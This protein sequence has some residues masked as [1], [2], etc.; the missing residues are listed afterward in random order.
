VV[1]GWQ[2]RNAH[3][4]SRVQ[5]VHSETAYMTDVALAWIAAQGESPWVLLLSY[6]KPHW[7]YLAPAPYHA[8]FRDSDTGPFVR[9]PQDGT[10]DEHPVLHAYR[11]HD[12]CLSFG[13]EDIARH[14]RPA[15]MGLVAQVDAHLGRV[16]RALEMSGRLGDTLIIFTSDHGEILGY[17][18]LGE[19][20]LFYDEIV[21]VPLIVA[22]PDGRADGTRG[23]HDPRFVE[24]IDV[25][26]TV[27]DALGQNGVAHRSEGRSLLPL[28]RGE[29]ARAWRDCVFSELDYSYRRARVVLGRRASA[30]RGF[31]VRTTEWKYV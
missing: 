10:A 2:M 5:E 16:F 26:P 9:S 21:R 29:T 20:E 31:M 14:V 6:V 27:L 28:L 4:P 19:K 8:L 12:E 17:R 23:H 22:D 30:C 13:R 3:L 25:V 18:G 15:Y 1:S 24:A 7:P 11:T